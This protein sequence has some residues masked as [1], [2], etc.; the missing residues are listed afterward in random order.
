[1]EWPPGGTS[2]FK[3]KR[4]ANGTKIIKLHLIGQVGLLVTKKG[5]RKPA[6]SINLTFIT[7]QG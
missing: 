5:W 2:L 6:L 7:P 1:M 3:A 4:E